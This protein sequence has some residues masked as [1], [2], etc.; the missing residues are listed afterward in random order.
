[1]FATK[2]LDSVLNQYGFRKLSVSKTWFD[3]TK[4]WLS[5]TSHQ[6]DFNRQVIRLSWLTEHMGNPLLAQID[7]DVVYRLASTKRE[8]TS[9]STANRHMAL[10]RAIL[11]AC[12]DDWGWL[13]WIPK[14]PFFSEPEHRCRWLYPNQAARLIQELPPHLSDMA[15]FTLATG[16]RQSNVTG[17]KT[18]SLDMDR[19]VAWVHSTQSKNKTSFTVPLNRTALSVLSRQSPAVTGEV[20]TYKQKPIKK[21]STAAWYKALERSGIT[22]FRWHDLRHTWASWHVQ[23]GTSIYELKELGGWKSLDMVLRYAHLG[24]DHMT[25]ASHRI[26]HKL[27]NVIQ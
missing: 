27:N 16:L 1:M 11:R 26:D 24:G 25:V 19:G 3:A 14:I 7:D 10:L 22:D 18:H 23:S 8:L 13:H 6:R 15:V 2:D 12:R 5:L 9:A 17:L 20:F 4:R 21:C